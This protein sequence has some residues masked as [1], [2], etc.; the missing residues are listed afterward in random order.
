MFDH[1]PFQLYN[2]AYLIVAYPQKIFHNLAKMRNFRFFVTSFSVQRCCFGANVCTPRLMLIEYLSA[3]PLM[4]S[5]CRKMLA[6]RRQSKTQRN[7]LYIPTEK[8]PKLA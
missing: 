3:V 1:E 2:V 5:M 8:G 4:Q 6:F 7:M